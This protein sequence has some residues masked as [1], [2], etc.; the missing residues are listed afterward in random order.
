MTSL[1]LRLLPPTYLLLLLSCAHEARM[2][3]FEAGVGRLGQDELVAQFGYPQRLKKLS[4]GQEAWDY[5]F[6]SG[7]SRCVGYRVFF[8]DDRRSTRWESRPCEAAQ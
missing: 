7:G 3:S 6:L 1:A 2:E 4:T 5:E 8:G